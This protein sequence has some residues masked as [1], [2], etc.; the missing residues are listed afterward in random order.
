MFM[1]GFIIVIFQIYGNWELHYHQR[2]ITDG[3]H[4]HTQRKSYSH[5]N[6]PSWT[7]WQCLWLASSLL[8]SSA[9]SL[10][11]NNQNYSTD[12]TYDKGNFKP[13]ISNECVGKCKKALAWRWKAIYRKW[14]R[15]SWRFCFKC[16][17]HCKNRWQ[18]SKSRISIKMFLKILNPDRI[19][20]GGFS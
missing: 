4:S 19:Y 7:W 1:S 9:Q 15:R 2:A 12:S 14:T 5:C 8:R 16:E 6:I 10:F 13:G 18:W 17:N 3:S 11:G 20:I